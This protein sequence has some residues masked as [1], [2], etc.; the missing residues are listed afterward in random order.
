MN[1]LIWLTYYTLTFHKKKQL[2][3]NIIFHNAC[4]FCHIIFLNSPEKEPYYLKI[5]T[6]EGGIRNRK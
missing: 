6:R 1:Y 5:Q 4:F 3:I 2:T